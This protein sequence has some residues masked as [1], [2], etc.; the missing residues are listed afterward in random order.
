MKGYKMTP[1]ERQQRRDAAETN[2]ESASIALRLARKSIEAGE[3]DAGLRA[4]DE[5]YRLYRLWRQ[6]QSY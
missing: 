2:S 3:T 1:E 5:H 4:L 6:N